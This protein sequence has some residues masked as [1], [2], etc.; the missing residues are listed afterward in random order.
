MQ[1]WKSEYEKYILISENCKYL[2][3]NY[4]GFLKFKEMMFTLSSMTSKQ[5]NTYTYNGE[6]YVSRL[7]NIEVQKIQEA[8][9]T[10]KSSSHLNKLKYIC[11]DTGIRAF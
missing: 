7:T 1:G 5:T 4:E 9:D 8:L 10:G 6:V 11:M 2:R 3:G